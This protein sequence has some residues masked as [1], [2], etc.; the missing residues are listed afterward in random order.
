MAKPH[1]VICP[2]CNGDVEAVD[3]KPCEGKGYIVVWETFLSDATDS[4]KIEQL[5][6][7]FK[8]S[9]GR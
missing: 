8:E 5:H 7:P 2:K 4:G 1:V 6:G 9:L 3:C